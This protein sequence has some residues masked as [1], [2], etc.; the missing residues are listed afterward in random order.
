M[1]KTHYKPYPKYK[2]SDVESIGEIPEGW[3]VR[4]YKYE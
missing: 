1:I 4:K 3:E 2:P